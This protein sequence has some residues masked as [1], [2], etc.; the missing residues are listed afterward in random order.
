MVA[1]SSDL[2]YLGGVQAKAGQ[3]ANATTDVAGKVYTN[4]KQRLPESA[5]PYVKAAED[6]FSEYGT[7]VL[8]T[9]QDKGGKLVQNADE[10]VRCSFVLC[11]LHKRLTSN[12]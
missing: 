2:K 11:H 6:K 7:P 1:E 10:K 3:A 5:Q 9:V 4:V 12:L 8:T